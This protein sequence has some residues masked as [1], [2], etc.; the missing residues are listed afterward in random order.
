[1]SQPD[2]THIESTTAAKDG[3]KQLWLSGEDIHTVFTSAA[4]TIEA[5]NAAAPWGTDDPGKEFNKNYLDGGDEAPA[6]MTLKAGRSVIDQAR[7]LGPSIGMAI[8]GS[9]DVD[10]LVDTWFGGEDK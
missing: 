3:A 2:E 10:E 8:D 1:M 5:L 7:T 9:V 4:S 6:T